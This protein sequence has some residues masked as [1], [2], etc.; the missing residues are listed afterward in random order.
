MAH[1]VAARRDILQNLLPPLCSASS[2]ICF[3]CADY[4]N[5]KAGAGNMDGIK[6]AQPAHSMV[7]ITKT[8]MVKFPKP[9]RY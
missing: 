8:Y 3:V 7:N 5:A 2:A 6:V 1:L 9:S 4:V